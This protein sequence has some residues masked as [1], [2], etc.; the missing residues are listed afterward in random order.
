MGNKVFL[1]LFTVAVLLVGLFAGSLL[2]RV[3]QDM[4]SGATAIPSPD[5]LPVS[6]TLTPSTTDGVLLTMV[7]GT[8]T[9]KPGDTVSLSVMADTRENALAGVDLEITFD[10]TVVDV[11]TVTRGSDLGGFTQEVRNEVDNVSGRIIYTAAT[12][13]LNDA[14]KGAAVELLAFEARVLPDAALGKYDLAFA[15]ETTLAGTEA[16]K[17]A[18]VSLPGNIEVVDFTAACNMIRG[19]VNADGKV[20]ILDI[21]AIIE[22]YKKETPINICTDINGDGAVNILDIMEVVKNYRP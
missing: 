20:N 1:S 19:D 9:V 8:L 3:N 14:V 12:L 18:M 15:P 6:P 11:Q 7:P 13:D 5:P 16:Q 21:V 10:P 4:R 2:V 22:D 17:L